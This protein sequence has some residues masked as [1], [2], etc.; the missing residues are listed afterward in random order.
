MSF[1]PG[2]FGTNSK[3]ATSNT[4]TEIPAQFQGYFNNMLG[5]A[6]TLSEQPYQAYGGQRLADTNA[7]ING[8][9]AMV[10]NIATSGQPITQNAIDMTGNAAAGVDQFIG[11]GPYQYSAYNYSNPE[12]FDSAAAQKYMSP[13]IQNVLNLQKEQA[14]RDYQTQNA[15]RAAQAVQSGAFGGSRQAVQQGMAENDLLNRNNMTEA[16]G[17]QNAYL[18]AQQMFGQDRA[19]QMANEQ[20]QAAEQA[21]VQGG[22]NAANNQYSQLGL[23]GLGFKSQ[24]A[25]QMSNLE[26]RAR[27]GDIQA[28]Q[29]L[30]AA[31]KGQQAQQQAGLDIGYQDYLRQQ[32]DATNKLNNFSSILQGLPI[33]RT[34]TDTTVGT[35]AQPSALQQTLGAGISALGLYN[36]WQ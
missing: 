5:R 18:N 25:L 22:Q 15:G 33:Q 6:Q 17:L 11:N 30:E 28:A 9:R 10:E 34:G 31:G 2:L 20:R 3:P 1:L 35:A 4:T 7:D 24:Q 26:Q 13:Y 32:N 29:L 23:Q 16:T 27:A 14:N 12:M 19:A 8:S 36:A 21:R